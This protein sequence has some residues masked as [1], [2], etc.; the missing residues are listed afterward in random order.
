MR[1]HP[2]VLSVLLLCGLIALAACATESD[3][4]P[5]EAVENYLTA[6]VAG[7]REAMSPLLCSA[8]EGNLSVEAASFA[9]VDARL[10]EP[11]CSRV[12]GTDTVTCTGS[13]VVTYGTEDRSLPLSTYRVTQE[14]DTWR[15]CGEAD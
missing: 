13:I 12:E 2:L 3:S 1:R 15:W 7:D 11:A 4:N 14:D 5:A 8:L 9:N 6:K 10:D